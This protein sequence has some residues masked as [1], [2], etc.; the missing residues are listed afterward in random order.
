[1]RNIRFFLIFFSLSL[2]LMVPLGLNGH[3]LIAYMKVTAI[4]FMKIILT[5]A[6]VFATFTAA[7]SDPEESPLR[8]QPC[9]GVV[10]DI[11]VSKEKIDYSV[12]TFGDPKHTLLPLEI[13]T[14]PRVEVND[15]NFDGC[16]DFSVWYLDEGMGKYAIH[17]VFIY[18][19]QT[20]TFIQAAPRCG[21]EFLNLRINKARR[22]LNS[23]YYSNNR[24]MTCTTRL[25]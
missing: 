23:T 25:K 21:E 2:L 1:M 17:R 13:E 22:S 15:F 10:V 6:F 12:T 8:F 4:K 9:P 19:R 3:G 14:Q 16:K 18:Q 24:A 20:Q 5:L 11:T 7:A